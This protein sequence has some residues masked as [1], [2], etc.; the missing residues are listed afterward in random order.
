MTLPTYTPN[1]LPHQVS[2]SYTLWFLR[3]SPD[4]TFKLKATLLRAKVKSTSHL[5]TTHLHPLTNVP[6]KYQHLNLTV[7][8][9][10]PGLAF[11]PLPTHPDVMGENSTHTALKTV[12]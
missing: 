3:Y 9:I 10:Q 5:D 12:G 4:K 11:F 1:K 8:A 7:S 2:T 6:I